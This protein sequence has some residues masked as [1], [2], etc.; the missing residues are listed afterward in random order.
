M[1]KVRLNL[2]CFFSMFYNEAFCLAFF[3]CLDS[4][5]F[6]H[7]FTFLFFMIRLC[8]FCERS[9]KRQKYKWCSFKLSALSK[10]QLFITLQKNPYERYRR[11]LRNLFSNRKLPLIIPWQFSEIL[12]QASM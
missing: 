9:R 4:C 10:K 7:K 1:G 11:L 5:F 6:L 8:T 2:S 3:R 12:K